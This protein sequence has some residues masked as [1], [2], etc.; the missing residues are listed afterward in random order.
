MGKSVTI[1]I[2]SDIVLLILNGSEPT[3]HRS[4]NYHTTC[5]WIDQSNQTIHI[6]ISSSNTFTVHTMTTGQLKGSETK[7][8]KSYF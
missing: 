2:K 6:Y 4:I 8:D 7:T 3:R 5:V 1:E